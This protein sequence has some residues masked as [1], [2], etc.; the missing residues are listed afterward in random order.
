MQGG[1][2][3]VA[4]VVFDRVD[5]LDVGGPYEVLLTA[6]RLALRDGRPPPFDVVTVGNGTAGAYG[7]LTLVPQA[8]FDDIGDVDLVV[9]P[10]A[11]DIEAVRADR[12]L[13]DP[14]RLLADRAATVAS[15]CTGAFLLADL[16]LLPDSWTTHWEDISELAA[17]VRSP[18]D[19]SVRWVDAGAVV[20]GGGL[21]S[22]IAMSLH[23]VARFAGMELALRVAKQ[24]DYAWDPSGA[25]T[26]A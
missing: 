6:S 19:P 11:V 10:G 8:S 20:T 24:I 17:A 12:G 2:L 18:G 15:V 1:A 23:L 13:M 9:V 21:S 25:R 16:G 14:L 4:I 26:P 3:R 5:L 7:G 22:G